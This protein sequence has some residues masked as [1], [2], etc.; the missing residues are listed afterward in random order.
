MWNHRKNCSQ[1]TDI[2]T[3]R[4]NKILVKI[5]IL[6][7]EMRIGKIANIASFTKSHVLPLT[8]EK[9]IKNEL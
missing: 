7:Y 2:A 4:L 1:T 5:T 8:K 9:L 6:N 3:Q